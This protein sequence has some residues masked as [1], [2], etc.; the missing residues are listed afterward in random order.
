MSLPT[1]LSHEEIQQRIP[2]K[3][4]M[5]LLDKV[6]AWSVDEI[7]CSAT[8]HLTSDHPL[9]AEGRLGVSAIIEYAAQAMA[10]HG[11]LL[12]AGASAPAAGYL[13]SIRQVKW[14]CDRLDTLGVPMQIR[15]TRLSGDQ[16]MVMYEF[17]AHAN[18]VLLAE[19]RLSAVLDI[20]SLAM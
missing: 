19:G 15:A 11:G 16:S 6:E 9:T 14:Y 10:V 5:C 20:R 1:Q 18:E 2:H 12:A 3:G 17:T 8:S 4:T 7:V 13:T